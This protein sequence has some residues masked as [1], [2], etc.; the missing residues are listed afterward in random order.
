MKKQKKRP[1][2]KEQ[3]N[4]IPINIGDVWELDGVTLEIKSHNKEYKIITCNKKIDDK[5]Q[6]KDLEILEN[7]FRKN[8][9]SFGAIRKKKAA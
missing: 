6:E 7:H 9:L 1:Y 4:I 8:I 5:N 3:L 2:T